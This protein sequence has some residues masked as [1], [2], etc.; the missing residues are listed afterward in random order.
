M[1][2]AVASTTRRAP[3]RARR[4][5]GRPPAPPASPEPSR[6]EPSYAAGSVLSARWAATLL[7]VDSA[8][9]ERLRRSA[10]LIAFADGAS[11]EA[12]YPVWQLAPGGVLAGTPRVLAAAREVA[13]PPERLHRLMSARV[14][15][16]GGQRLADLLRAGRDDY[17]V[18]RVRAA[19]GR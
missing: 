8:E 10:E 19:A 2:D 3:V 5:A 16:A 17:V 9:L 4:A 11:G 15:L 12:V 14:G 6:P 18:D 13:L 1:L 7:A